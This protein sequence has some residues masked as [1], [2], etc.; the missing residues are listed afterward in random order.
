[1]SSRASYPP[2]LFPTVPLLLWY[3]YI[4]T[5]YWLQ[6][7]ERVESVEKESPEVAPSGLNL[8]TVTEVSGMTLL[9]FL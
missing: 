7:I 5:I 6:Q 4:M 2:V 1:M 8:Q 3:V 9:R